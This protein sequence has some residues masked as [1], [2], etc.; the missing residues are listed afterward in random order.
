MLNISLFYIHALWVLPRVLESG[1]F[2]L[3]KIS[4]LLF[5]IVIY[6]MLVLLISLF[7]IKVL[8]VNKDPKSIF[9]KVS[10]ANTLFRCIYLILY[11]TGYYFLL[12]FI[13]NKKAEM[14]RKVRLEQLNNKLLEANSQLLQAEVDYLRAQINPH[15]LFNTLSFIKHSA[16]HSPEDADE[17]IMLLSGILSFA[18]QG[19]GKETVILKDEIIQ[20]ENIIRLNQLRFGDRL[21]VRFTQNIQNY[22]TPIMPIVLLTLVEN[23]FKHGELHDVNNPAEIY[24]EESFGKVVYRTR[25]LVAN[26]QLIPSNNTG[27]QN[28]RVRLEKSFPGR[29]TFNHGLDGK[30]FKVE[31]EIR[32]M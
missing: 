8:N 14:A 22:N 10:F 7:L 26:D 9:T 12:N 32:D 19:G 5:E 17:A 29:Y 13:R 25:N 2:K 24:V 28:I 1:K 18:T 23:V 15:L 4:F 30:Q 20:V 27:L 11:G 31:I 16:K 6:I 21:N 3:W